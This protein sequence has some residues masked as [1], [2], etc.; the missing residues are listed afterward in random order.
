MYGR[1]IKQINRHN[2]IGSLDTSFCLSVKRLRVTGVYFRLISYLRL[3]YYHLVHNVAVVSVSTL[4]CFI[5]YNYVCNFDC[6][7]ISVSQ[8]TTDMFHLS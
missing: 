3:Y 7:G 4:T 2:F 1:V 8:M 6:Y 5:R